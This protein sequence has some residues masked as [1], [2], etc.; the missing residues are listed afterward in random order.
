MEG[1]YEYE[2]ER[3]ELLGVEPIS[4]ELWEEQAKARREQEIEQEQNDVAEELQ[5]EE[6]KVKTTHGK[7]EELNNILM[8]TQV[9][10]NKFKVCEFL[11]LR[12]LNF[13]QNK[14][15]L[16]T[17]CGSFTS[18]LKIRTGSPAPGDGPSGSNGQ[19]PTSS[20][21]DALDDLDEMK[22]VEQQ[23][24]L[25]FAKGQAQDISQ[26]ASKNLDALDRLIS[27]AETAEISLQRQNQQMKGLLRK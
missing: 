19:A 6:E 14:C 5:A 2:L 27:K 24:D 15:T 18:L 16:Q 26:K 17:V 9:K 22:R 7:M 23:S 1:T 3:A 11:P 12:V 13:A 21:N 8:S 10:L 4:R 25:Q 20:I